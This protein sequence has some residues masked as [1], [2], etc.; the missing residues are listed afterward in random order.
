MLVKGNKLSFSVYSC[1]AKS[2]GKLGSIWKGYPQYIPPYDATLFCFGLFTIKPTSTI[3]IKVWF[4]LC[5]KGVAGCHSV[6]VK[7]PPATDSGRTARTPLNPGS[8]D[9]SFMG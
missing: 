1:K 5:P 9:R 2:S 8:S 4:T 6:R 7:T 3:A